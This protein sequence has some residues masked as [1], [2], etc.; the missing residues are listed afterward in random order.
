MVGQTAKVVTLLA[1]DEVDP[2]KLAAE[3]GF[4]IILQGANHGNEIKALDSLLEPRYSHVMS[5]ADIGRYMPDD[6]GITP[7]KAGRPS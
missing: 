1:V 3:S 2:G 4:A 7:V 6:V 5:I